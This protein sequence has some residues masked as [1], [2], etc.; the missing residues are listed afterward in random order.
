M[1]VNPKWPCLLCIVILWLMIGSA[2][3]DTYPRDI[4]IEYDSR[5][6]G[7]E[8][9]ELTF[10]GNSMKR[11]LGM[12]KMHVRAG[13][14]SMPWLEKQSPM[15]E[16]SLYAFCVEFGA[17]I[18]ND[19]AAHYRTVDGETF[20]MDPVQ[21]EMMGRFYT[22]AYQDLLKHKDP[23]ERAIYS[24]AM[25]V[26][27]WEL[28]YDP[29]SVN[30]DSGIYQVSS[31]YNPAVKKQA[32]YWLARIATVENIYSFT[33]L[34]SEGYQDLI[35]AQPAGYR[36]IFSSPNIKNLPYHH[37]DY[38]KDNA[39]VKVPEPPVFLMMV[40]AMMVMFVSKNRGARA[41]EA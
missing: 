38:G 29:L 6:H 24:A 3:A 40:A 20:L 14:A 19:G 15:D 12:F 35:V 9:I 28:L 21:L 4:Y 22:L 5:S 2:K 11:K 39:P 10:A 41:R 1:Q 34:K 33:V 8:R 7:S 26:G 16:L 13:G 32:N 17:P 37:P 18:K 23:E 36:F 25:Q 27:V 30:L 31:D